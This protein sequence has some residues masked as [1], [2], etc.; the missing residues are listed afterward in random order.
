M[1]NERLQ[2]ER[3]LVMTRL[4]LPAGLLLLGLSF[5]PTKRAERPLRT[6]PETPVLELCLD[7]QALRMLYLLRIDGDQAKKLQV[8]AKE[9]AAP[10]RERDKPRVSDDYRRVLVGLREALA[11]DN[12]EKVEELEDRLSELTDTEGPELDDG[13][14]VTAVARRRVPEAVRL[15]R[16]QQL[17]SYFGSTAEEIGDP[18]ERLVAALQELRSDKAVDWEDSRDDLADDLGWLL[19]G[20]DAA[21]AKTVR[22]EVTALVNKAHKLHD[23]AFAKQKADLEQEARA[24]GADVG[25][26]KVLQHAVERTLARLLSNPRLVPALEARLKAAK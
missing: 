2:L 9:I 16:P 19:G 11:A 15:L 10:D 4:L 22:E 13:V 24:I 14:N 8:I 25:S 6:E 17:A 1:L 18:Q 7:V 21:R 26:M 12:E 5:I 3:S 20:L 23:D